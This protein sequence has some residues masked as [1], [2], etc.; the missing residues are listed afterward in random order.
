MVQPAIKQ[1]MTREHLVWLFE[2]KGSAKRRSP[3]TVEVLLACDFALENWQLLPV[4]LPSLREW[5]GDAYQRCEQAQR[6]DDLAVAVRTLSVVQ[7]RLC[8]R[9]TRELENRRIPYALLKG[10]AAR[11]AAYPAVTDRCGLDVDIGVPQHSIQRA[12]EVAVEQG[13][14]PA[15][16]DDTKRRFFVVGDDERRE[17]EEE[18]YEL[19]CLVR[20]QAVQ[21]LTSDAEGA[22]RRSIE[23]I[24]PW[25][26]TPDGKVACYVTFDIHHGLSLDISVDELVDTSCRATSGSYTASVP[27]PSWLIF[28]LIFKL[29]WEGVHAY[30]KGGYQYADLVRVVPKL[31]EAETRH[32]LALIVEFQL[33]AAAFFVLRRL[34]SM[35]GTHLSPALQD[36]LTVT[37]V[38]PVDRFPNDV[39]DL[40]DM[41]PKLWGY[42]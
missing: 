33:E 36:F 23:L 13:F 15:S 24:K 22:I 30:R 27:R 16:L 3:D 12:E 6:L 18:H 10:A 34:P 28:H 14:L 21:G 42:R 26:V 5:A 41:W 1:A 4:I 20:R 35:F 37:A 2:P 31:D 9:F 7:M 40:G 32:L 17:V 29:Y 8:E 38:P 19:A 25:H 11:V 39:N